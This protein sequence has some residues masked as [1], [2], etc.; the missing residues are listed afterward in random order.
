MIWILILV[1]S[2][3]AGESIAVVPHFSSEAECKAAGETAVKAAPTGWAKPYM[4]YACV[5]GSRALP[6]E[7][8]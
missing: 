7:P 8:Q 1:L 4:K 6:K 5:K 3:T 2:T